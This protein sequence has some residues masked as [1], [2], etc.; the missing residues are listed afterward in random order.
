MIR[1][2]FLTV[3]KSSEVIPGKQKIS[4]HESDAAMANVSQADLC[5]QLS[6]L[7]RKFG[8]DILE[9]TD[10]NTF[11]ANA[12]QGAIEIFIAKYLGSNLTLKELLLCA[13]IIC[14]FVSVIAKR[15]D[16][17]FEIAAS[18]A[19]VTFFSLRE[20]NNTKVVKF[21][22]QVTEMFNDRSLGHLAFRKEIS[23]EFEYFLDYI[24]CADFEDLCDVIVKH[25][26][27][28]FD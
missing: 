6:H 18:N 11:A 25:F 9:D 27:K 21:H 15:I 26:D 12:A 10:E 3:L 17:N 8:L 28:L 1:N 14:Y 20:K 13:V 22:N 7:Y 19:V 24:E 4:L 23:E 5:N 16:A 2:N